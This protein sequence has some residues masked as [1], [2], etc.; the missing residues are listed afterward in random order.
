MQGKS[1]L[2]KK[3]IS[4]GG[5]RA[6]SYEFCND[7]DVEYCE[8]YYIDRIKEG[9]REYWGVYIHLSPPHVLVVENV[10]NRIGIVI[11][12]LTHHIEH[13]CYDVSGQSAHGYSYQLAKQRVIT[14]AKNNISATAPWHQPLKG[15]QEK[16]EQIAFKI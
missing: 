9:D 5:A 8:I 1:K 15:Y 14:W 2:W 4:L 12:E 6:L 13:Q 16:T 3:Q 10:I 7:F 11:H